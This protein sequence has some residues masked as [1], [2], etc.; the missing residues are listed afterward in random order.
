M[1]FGAPSASLIPPIEHI[2]A[3]PKDTATEKSSDVET[4]HTSAD[5]EAIAQ[6]LAHCIAAKT[7]MPA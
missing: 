2:A 3:I 4:E 5:T 1:V 7:A 6:S